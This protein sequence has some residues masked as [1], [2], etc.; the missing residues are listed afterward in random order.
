MSILIVKGGKIGL[1]TSLGGG[2]CSTS[3]SRNPSPLS[4]PLLPHYI[5]TSFKIITAVSKH[6][7]YKVKLTRLYVY[8]LVRASVKTLEP[9]D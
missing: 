9:T 5:L 3:L 1:S 4:K 8:W 7:K 2:Y 6:G